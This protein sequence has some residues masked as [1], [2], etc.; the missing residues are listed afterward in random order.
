M[1]TLLYKTPDKLCAKL[2][3][4]ITMRTCFTILFV[5]PLFVLLNLT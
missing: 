5:I 4:T 2:Y 3:A 1:Q